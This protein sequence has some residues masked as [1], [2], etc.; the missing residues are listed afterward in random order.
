MIEYHA[1]FVNLLWPS[2]VFHHLRGSNSALTWD[3]C[4]GVNN[5]TVCQWFCSCL[6]NKLGACESCCWLGFSSVVIS[7]QRD[8]FWTITSKKRRKFTVT[9]GV[10][11]P[12]LTRKTAVN[13]RMCEHI[14]MT[15]IYAYCRVATSSGSSIYGGNKGH[16]IRSKKVCIWRT[17]GWIDRSNK[18]RNTNNLTLTQTK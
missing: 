2:A 1:A 9:G 4:G 3:Q 15:H 7:S 10:I 5:I 18:H 14:I 8:I 6:D 17:V 12:V 13:G 11:Q 16:C